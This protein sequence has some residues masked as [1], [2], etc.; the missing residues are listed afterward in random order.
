MAGGFSDGFVR[1]YEIAKK[2]FASVK[3]EIV[4]AHRGRVTTIYIVNL[5]R[6][7]V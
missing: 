1:C 2:P 6:I 3:W 5:Y 4:N 7:F